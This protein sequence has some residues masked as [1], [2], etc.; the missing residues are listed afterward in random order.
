VLFLWALHPHYKAI[1]DL[2]ASKQ[3]DISVTSINS[4]ISD[5]QFMDDFSFFGSNGNPDPVTDDLLNT[6][7]PPE[8]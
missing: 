2:F 1:I 4:I 7:S 6:A 3:K 5:A 8:P